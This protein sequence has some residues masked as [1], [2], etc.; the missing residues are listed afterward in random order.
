ML[1]KTFPIFRARLLG[2]FLSCFTGFSTV[3]AQTQ[4][5]VAEI[6]ASPGAWAYVNNAGEVIPSGSFTGIPPVSVLTEAA[7]KAREDFVFTADD[8]VL[9]CGSPGMPRALTAGSP[10]DFSW[11][12]S[13]SSM[14]FDL[15]INRYESMDITRM[16]FMDRDTVPAGTARTPDGFA[17]GRWEGNT[18][19]IETS[20]MDTRI[21][22]LLGTPKSEQQTLEERY[23]VEIVNGET[24]LHLDL[25]MTDP[26]YYREPY[27][28]E[29]TFKLMPDWEI[30]L[31]GCVERPD[32]LMPGSVPE[33]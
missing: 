2:L 23:D 1:M 7:L 28:W 32:D 18:L 21:Q 8:P 5:E 31:Y 26:V 9:G 3:L 20:H 12:N 14:R 13:Y 22:D 30:A 17:R 29:F 19:V 16:I 27:V 6:L 4:E 11:N 15:L 25:I 10:M 24:F 33:N